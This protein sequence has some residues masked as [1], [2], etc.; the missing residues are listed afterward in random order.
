[1][2]Y[3]GTATEIH[4]DNDI[5]P[6]RTIVNGKF[7]PW[8]QRISILRDHRQHPSFGWKGNTELSSLK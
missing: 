5:T 6:N 8:N 7:R 3:I 1:M 2:L 4:V